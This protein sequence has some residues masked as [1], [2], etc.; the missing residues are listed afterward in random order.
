MEQETAQLIQQAEALFSE[1]KYQ[2]IIALLTDELLNQNNSGALYACRAKAYDRLN[3]GELATLYADK[4]IQVDP[5]FPLLYLIKGNA[6]HNK[7]E[8]EKAIE[9]YN[10]AIALDEKNAIAYYN[11][12]NTWKAKKEYDKAI[13]D[14]NKAIALDEKLAM[15]YNNRGNAWS[16][17]KEYDKA[18]EDY[19]K[20]IAL[21]EKYAKA[22]NN[23]GLA[24]SAKKEHDKAIE[25][26]T[27]AIA[28][29]E[30]YADAYYNRARAYN[31]IEEFAQAIR[32]DKKYIALTNDREE[33]YSQIAESKIK[34]LEKK[35]ANTWY[36][37]ITELVS[38]IKKL[39]LF[40]QDC[41][42]HYTGLSAAKAMILDDKKFRLSEGAFLN[43]TSEGRELF[44]YLNFST[45]KPSTDRTVAEPFSEKPFIG[46]FVTDAKHDD[47]T[48]WRMYGKEDKIEAKGCALTINKNL[49]LSALKSEKS[50]DS[51][52]SLQT[53]EQFTFYK[54]AYRV[55]DGQDT[56]II[57]GDNSGG[58]ALAGLMNE[59]REKVNSLSVDEEISI[60]ELLNGIAFLFKSSAYQYE[61]EVRLIV[62]GVGFDKVIDKDSNP[63]KVYIELIKII[64]ALTKITFGPKVE[65]ADEWAAAFNYQ[66]KK[67]LK[68]SKIEIII[69]HL[70]FK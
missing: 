10:K 63:P 43:D 4:A 22:Y 51:T 56:F 34:E 24:W 29:D 45:I 27:K 14:Y 37:E 21:D 69:S 2:E 57:P 32:D 60:K 47:L 8:Y 15:A 31:I 59:L 55:K 58:T 67:D 42:T 9:D 11:R 39:L 28:L 26:Y 49:F 18:I 12:G 23:R 41:V 7:K 30:K 35:L 54:V 52:G 1:K 20:A 70:P 3:N 65:K 61:N 48:L 68:D 40:E 38:K 46:S 50:K 62:Q 13:E 17:K 5:S 64:P 44:E 6:W 16:D 66:I 53:E 36:N 19:T 25:D 33:Y